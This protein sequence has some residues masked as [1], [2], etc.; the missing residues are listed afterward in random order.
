MAVV[1]DF[2]GNEQGV[3][4]INYAIIAAMIGL[5]VLIGGLGLGGSLGELYESFGTDAN[6]ALI[7]N[8]PMMANP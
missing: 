3:A 6:S 5:A 7:G 2:L 4:A 1:Q 8:V